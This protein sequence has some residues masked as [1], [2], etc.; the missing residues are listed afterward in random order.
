ME[1]L[2]HQEETPP[3]PPAT[4]EELHSRLSLLADVFHSGQNG[5]G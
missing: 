3:P 1:A 5:Q 2:G 4:A